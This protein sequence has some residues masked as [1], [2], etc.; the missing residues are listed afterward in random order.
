MP[1]CT[2]QCDGR[3][4]G[5]DPNCGQ[6]CGTCDG[7]GTFCNGAGQCRAPRVRP[8]H[9]TRRGAAPSLVRVP[10]GPPSAWAR[11]RL[12]QRSQRGTSQY[13]IP[14]RFRAGRAGIQPA[15]ALQYGGT[16]HNG[17]A[18]IGWHIEGL[19]KIT[20]CPK[21]QALD[22]FAWP[23]GTAWATPFA[24][25]ANDRTG[26]GRQRVTRGAY[27]ANGTEYRTLIDSF[28]RIVSYQ[29]T[30]SPGVQLGPWAGVELI[31]RLAQAPDPSP[32]GRKKAESSPTVARAKRPSWVATVRATAGSCAASK[33]VRQLDDDFS[34]RTSE[35][36]SAI[37]FEKRRA[38][39]IRPPRDSL[40]RVTEAATWATD[41][42]NLHTRRGAIPSIS[43]C[44]EAYRSL[45]T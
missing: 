38:H 8:R 16:S 33:S 2:P 19:S 3:Q 41:K 9:R 11:C 21:V 17:D 39:V 24:S 1:V 29:D 40:V 4:C 31:N 32:F 36:R 23:F 12:V 37:S 26:E 7:P 22:Q 14:S 34:T 20:R 28:A 35:R 5:P 18:G 27:G 44:R 15:L 43:S 30:G 42:F 25:M 10:P 13:S 6:S 45:P